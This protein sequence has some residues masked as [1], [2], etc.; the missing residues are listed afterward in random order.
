M[1]P[2]PPPIAVEHVNHRYGEGEASNQVLFDNTLTVLPGEIVIMTGPSGSGKTTLLTLVGGLRSVQEG[3]VRV[4]GREL[5]GLDTRGLVAVRRQIGF[6]F[7]RHNLLEALT[8]YQNVKMALDLDPAGAAREHERIVG[9]LTGL[10]LA[11]RM[12]YK[13]AKLSGGQRQRVAIARALANR[14]R[15]ILADEPT[16]A[17]D[18]ESS[19]T[20]V[21]RLQQLAKGP[22]R[23]TSV[24]VT[25]DNR[26]LDVADRIINMVD[27]RIKSNVVVT[28]SVLGA[29]FLSKCPVFAG[30]TPDALAQMADQMDHERHPAGEEIIRQGDPGDKFYLIRRGTVDV[31]KDRG[32]PAE[33]HEARLGEGDFFGERALLTNEPRNATVIARDDVETYALD[34]KHFQEAL[35]ASASLKEQLLKAYFQRQ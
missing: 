27:G 23:C 16:A 21:G 13:P 9:L 34:K 18:A 35:E 11:D 4:F 25:H 28:E 30:L 17:L 6:I 10:G 2:E 7:Q 24:I 1:S 14:P 22:D 26:I 12:H 31:V 3:S 19:R 5:R 32:T 33:R 29:L 15:L 20:V 8:A